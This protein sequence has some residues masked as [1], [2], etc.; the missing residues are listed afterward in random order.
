MQAN[1]RSLEVKNLAHDNTRMAIRL[2]V[3]AKYVELCAHL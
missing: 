3:G 1:S 2:K